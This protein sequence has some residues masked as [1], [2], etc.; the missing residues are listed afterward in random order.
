MRKLLLGIF[1]ATSCALSISAFADNTD[2]DRT[3]SVSVANTGYESVHKH[4]SNQLV[5]L[6][7]NVSSHTT[8]TRDVQWPTGA[9]QYSLTYATTDLQDG[10]TFLLN[11]NDDGTLTQAVPHT[12]SNHSKCGTEMTR[13]G[14]KIRFILT[15]KVDDSL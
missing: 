1:L 9:R 4:A 7:D 8:E 13:T 3:Q 15:V 10:C 11:F 14:S 6:P 5:A 12:L 2:I